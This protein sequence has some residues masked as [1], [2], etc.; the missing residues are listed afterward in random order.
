MI[1]GAPGFRRRF[2]VEPGPAAVR[3]AVEDDYHCMAV[4]LRHDGTR[5]AAV[6]AVMDR[7]PWT[8]CPGAPA[9]LA[10][11]FAGLTL[12][13]AVRA[14]EKRTNCT[15][16]HDLA[17]LAAAHA[18][19]TAALVYDILVSDPVDG[20]VHAEIRRDGQ[21]LL[22]LS[23]RD[24]VV[25]APDTLAGTSLYA[26]RD[27]IAGLPAALHEPARLLQWG[28][29][30]AH[31]RAIPMDRQSDATRIPPN[32][33]TFQDVRKAEAQRVGLVLDFSQGSL[34]P[35]GHLGAEGFRR[36]EP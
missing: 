29:I 35:L 31:G 25:T 14:G 4:T 15:H 12:A 34:E 22:G 21:T 3:A 7:A 19:D 18:Q 16:L 33:Y 10:Q 24:D 2:R 11:T 30:L 9:V 32:C 36:R 27:W 20:R 13:E 6:E 5:I 8:T 28:T 17:G 26:L 23:H 1:D